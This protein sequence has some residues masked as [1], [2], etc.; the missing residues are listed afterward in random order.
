M[1]NTSLQVLEIMVDEF[2]K[3]G[4]LVL[5]DLHCLSTKGTNA[6]PVFFDS[7]HTVAQALQGWGKL[8]RSFGAKKNVLGGDVFNE[9]L[10]PRAKGA[11]RVASINAERA[12]KR[13][14]WA[15]PDTS[16]LCAFGKDLMQLAASSCSSGAGRLD[17]HAAGEEEGAAKEQ[18]A[19]DRGPDVSPVTLERA[20]ECSGSEFCPEFS[21]EISSVGSA[22]SGSPAAL[23][24]RLLS[25]GL[26]FGGI[27]HDAGDESSSA[28]EVHLERS[29]ATSPTASG[30]AA[31]DPTRIFARRP[32]GFLR[33]RRLPLA[34]T[35]HSQQESPYTPVRGESPK[36]ARAPK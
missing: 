8:A 15:S 16:E 4:I 25:L 5:L 7:S 34:R 2:A 1:Q 18:E 14:C 27:A 6:S 19:I 29:A 28:R 33:E 9:P 31:A 32:S 11:A 12:K 17:S 20:T 10:A 30:S 24:A 35:H 36:V 26:L 22:G 23:F 3:R 13:H 21:P